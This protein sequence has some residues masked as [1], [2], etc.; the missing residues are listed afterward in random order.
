LKVESMKIYP[1]PA[2]QEITIDIKLESPLEGE[3][4]IANI[5]GQEIKILKSQSI[6]DKG[7]NSVKCELIG[8]KPGIYL[9]SLITKSGYKT[10]R[11]IVSE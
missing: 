7:F 3:I 2:Q 5:A 11:I 6:F 4:S 1:N 10:E 8:I 9:V